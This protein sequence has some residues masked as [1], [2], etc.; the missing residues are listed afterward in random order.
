MI[1]KI[2][3]I[4]FIKK[5]CLK[6]E[7][8]SSIIQP[9]ACIPE[10]REGNRGFTNPGEDGDKPKPEISIQTSIFINL[11]FSTSLKN[12]IEKLRKWKI[13][14]RFLSF[15]ILPIVNEIIGSFYEKSEND[16]ALSLPGAED[17]L[18]IIFIPGSR[19]RLFILLLISW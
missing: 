3:Y 10:F 17:C 7:P 2:S 16:P 9:G 1:M 14:S 6:C 12:D 18:F 19:L 15:K 5:R 8:C 13:W 11:K 4:Q